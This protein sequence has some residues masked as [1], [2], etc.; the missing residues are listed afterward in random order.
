MAKGAEP[1]ALT[2]VDA[3]AR[4]QN[5]SHAEDHDYT[6]GSPHLADPSL[7]AR[8]DV[9]I[10]S[11]VV[12]AIERQGSC[13]VL[14]IGAG[15]GSFTDTVIAAGG[16]PTVTE[17]SEASYRHLSRKFAGMDSVRAVFDPDGAAL[18]R[19]ATR[20]DLILLISVIHHIPDYLHVVAGLCDDKLKPDGAILTFQ[21][22]LWYPR[23]TRWTR[24]LTTACYLLWRLTQ[25]EFKRGLRT[26][27]RRLRGVYDDTEPSD[28]V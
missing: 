24:L 18:E 12:E 6:T 2:H 5:V 7:R 28:L 4:S 26:R 11:L 15:H 16:T 14:E 8:L 27:L 19:D 20:F 9:R 1:D 13:S 22:P 23:M 25:G 21:D 10:R 3:I 17:M